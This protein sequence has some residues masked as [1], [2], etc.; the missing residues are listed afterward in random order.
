ML[1]STISL[2]FSLLLCEME[3]LWCTLFNKVDSSA[4]HIFYKMF[5]DLLVMHVELEKP[6]TCGKVRHSDAVVSTVASQQEGTLASSHHP[7]P[8]IGG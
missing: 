8:W 3:N 5:S 2:N 4:L 6:M 7:K 1:L